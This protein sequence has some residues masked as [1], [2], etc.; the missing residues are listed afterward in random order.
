MFSREL[1]AES[2]VFL[3]PLCAAAVP[4]F[5]A[6]VE[7]AWKKDVLFLNHFIVFALCFGERT[8]NDSYFCLRFYYWGGLFCIG[9]FM[10]L[11]WLP[12][13][14]FVC[15]CLVCSLL[16]SGTAAWTLMLPSTPEVSD[17]WVTN[18]IVERRVLHARHANLT[19]SLTLSTWMLKDWSVLVTGERRREFSISC[20]GWGT[21]WLMVT[22]V[23]GLKVLMERRSDSKLQRQAQ[24]FWG[25]REKMAWEIIVPGFKKT[26][27]EGSTPGESAVCLLKWKKFLPC[28]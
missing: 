19:L 24:N 4:L 20:I 16:F 22:E 7:L 3:P 17:F 18:S 9:N 5:H 26:S 11:P 12:A 10:Q 28:D 14:G 13:S 6:F 2:S 8:S 27:V 23:K 25:L 21:I 15:S 1:L